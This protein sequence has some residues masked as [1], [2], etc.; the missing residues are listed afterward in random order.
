MLMLLSCKAMSFNKVQRKIT[1]IIWDIFWIQ[2]REM[3]RVFLWRDCKE[4]GEEQFIIL[5]LQNQSQ[6]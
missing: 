2:P 5:L 6:Q 1:L 4:E 3:E